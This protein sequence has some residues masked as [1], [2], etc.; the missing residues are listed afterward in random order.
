MEAVAATT[1]PARPVIISV[2]GTGDTEEGKVRPNWWEATSDF[3]SALMS[4]TN[5]EWIAFRWSGANL[6]SERQAHA[7]LLAALV[8]RLLGEDRTVRIIAHSHGGNVARAA[9]CQ[10]KHDGGKD[11]EVVAVATPFFLYSSRVVYRVQRWLTIFL[12]LAVNVPVLLVY[13]VLWTS[14]MRDG[15]AAWFNLPIMIAILVVPFYSVSFLVGQLR[16]N[17]RIVVPADHAPVGRWTCIYSDNDEAIALLHFLAEPLRRTM[18]DAAR[19]RRPN[20]PS[21]LTYSGGLSLYDAFWGIVVI[22]LVAAFPL[23]LRI[24]SDTLIVDPAGIHSGEVLSITQREREESLASC[25]TWSVAPDDTWAR[26]NDALRRAFCERRREQISRAEVRHYTGFWLYPDSVVADLLD[27]RPQMTSSVRGNTTDTTDWWP[28]VFF[29]AFAL[30][31]VV[32]T[33]LFAGRATRFLF[34]N[35]AS[36]GFWGAQASATLLYSI[37]ES[38]AVTRFV[39]RIAFGDD[40]QRIIGVQ[41][42]P[43]SEQSAEVIEIKGDVHKALEE[44]VA[45]SYSTTMSKIRSALTPQ[46]GVAGE[47]RWQEFL[48][49]LSWEELAHTAYFKVPMCSEQIVNECR[50]VVVRDQ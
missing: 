16:F 36:S 8:D 2:H 33:L 39:R 42:Q 44:R 27:H 30:L 46:D 28:L 15:A 41:L 38:F 37:A 22:V 9:L 34:V 18:R 40:C 14:L 23:G 31:V 13:G 1:Q 48:A 29:F 19:K 7:T 10:L 43:W 50:K 35:V 4:G 47:R 24:G 45:N 5:A 21:W 17:P 49:C 26:A 11:V 25:D 6:E 3:A 12:A 32:P 20:A